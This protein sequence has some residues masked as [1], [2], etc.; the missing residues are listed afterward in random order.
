MLLPSV[1]A[2]NRRALLLAGLAT[3]LVAALVMAAAAQ[4]TREPQ[5][6]AASS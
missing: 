5:P 6:A 4:P 1:I 2:V 3:F